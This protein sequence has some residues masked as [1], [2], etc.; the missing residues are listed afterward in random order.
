MTLAGC[1]NIQKNT[2]PTSS[3][4]ETEIDTEIET[5]QTNTTD[6]D[7]N[8][9][10]AYQF[11]DGQRKYGYIDRSGI[12]VIH[13]QYLYGSDFSEGLAIVND[14]NF[15][16]VLNTAGDVLF[17]N[18]GTIET[19][20][21]GMA[22]FIDQATY[23]TGYIDT[24]GTVVIKPTYLMATPFKAD[25]TAIVS[26][27]TDELTLIDKSATALKAIELG[28]EYTGLYDIK[29]DYAL[30]ISGGQDGSK[31]GVVSLDGQL[32]IPAVYNGI[33][34]LGNG[35]FDVKD[36]TGEF[37][38]VIDTPS[39]IFDHTGKKLTDYIYY[40]VKPYQGDYASA[41]D[42]TET[43][44]IGRDGKRVESLP[45]RNGIGTLRFTG[46][47]IK[48]DID[49]DLSYLSEDDTVIW[50]ADQTYKLTDAITIKRNT[51]RLHR[52]ALVVYPTISG[53]EDE[54]VQADINA[55]LKSLFIDNRTEE[56]LVGLSVDDQF[57]VTLNGNLLTIHKS[58]YDYPTGAAHGMPIREYYQ[59]DIM[60]G[61]LYALKDLFVNNS[62][63][64]E[65]LDEVL[66]E[67]IQKSYDSGNTMVFPESFKGLTE[68]T[69]FII[70]KDALVIY[71][72]PYDIAAY[73]AG[74]QEFSIPYEDLMPIIDV[75]GALWNSFEH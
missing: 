42:G 31:I 13:P 26:S 60:T 3:E 72:Y 36:P 15:Y 43:F 66:V 37:Y 29:D 34:N 23:K 61:K 30:F 25:G 62:R 11:V 69:N 33:T 18:E 73:A 17:Q 39:A 50:Q 8:L 40:D 14:G 71:F 10:L 5:T 74:F 1:G 6:S 56:S 16:K 59:F 46:D 47:L 58:G 21:N 57:D 68:D 48:A 7:T 2:P 75:D 38:D 67:S 19:F 24:T 32:I 54:Q 55:N 45:K 27:T 20:Q 63:Y 64:I 41:N 70:T 53:L 51:E 9:Y 28:S 49:G 65:T 4:V 35:F 12:F 22:A 52:T 44:F